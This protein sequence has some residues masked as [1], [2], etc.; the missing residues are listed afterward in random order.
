V[1]AGRKV[2]SEYLTLGTYSAVGLIAF[3]AIKRAK[4][5]KPDPFTSDPPINAS[6]AEEEKYVY[7]FLKNA[8][9]EEKKNAH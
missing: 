8:E 9:A 5:R 7:D 4:A 1:I 3:L 2:A 6:S